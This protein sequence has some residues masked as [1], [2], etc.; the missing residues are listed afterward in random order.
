MTRSSD[1]YERPLIWKETFYCE[2]QTC[3]SCV[4]LFLTTV[5]QVVQVN[6]E[7]VDMFL[8]DVILE[9]VGRLADEQ[10]REEIRTRAKELNDVA[11][12][13]EER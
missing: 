9:S 10:A 2:H 6:Q 12:V 7:S 5:T 11:Y 3:F 8:E 13:M 4:W 1:K